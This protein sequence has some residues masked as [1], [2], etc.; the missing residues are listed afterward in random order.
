MKINALCLSVLS[1]FLFWGCTSSGAETKQEEVTTPSVKSDFKLPRSFDYLG[2][3]SV[4]IFS[5]TQDWRHDSGIAG[6]SA[7]WAAETDKNG[8]G[9]FTTEAPE[10]FNQTYLEKFSVII[11]NSMTGS[12][13]LN[14]SQRQALQKFVE[15]GGGI[16]LQH[17]SGDGSAG[18]NWPWYKELVGT[19]FI[20]HPAD[21]Q[22]QMAM[23]VTL[24]TDHPVML[25]LEEGFS[26]KD[27]WYSF[28]GPVKGKVT[29][30]AG[31]DESTYSPVNNVYGDV[32]D[33]RMGP[34]ATDHP[35]VW[36]KCPGQGRM[37][38]SALGH[39]V[40]SYENE[41][42]LTLLRNAMAWV[43]QERDPDGA[44]CPQ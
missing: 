10:I 2:E 29:V 32:S 28:E 25:G 4:L 15:E 44:F 20:G 27:E 41:A 33:L 5:G 43:R 8:V 9:L 3:N 11:L 36:A 12:Q 39:H 16:I 40:E 35:I 21:P 24:A 23:V 26:H 14:Q 13:I 31:L 1:P 37:V 38:Y 18:E 6:A 7:F 34:E 30:L 42:H 17:G 19:T 22:F